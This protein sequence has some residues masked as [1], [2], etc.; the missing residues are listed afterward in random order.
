MKNRRARE[1]QSA[2]VAAE[3][4]ETRSQT[5]GGLSSKSA[6]PDEIR[7]RYRSKISSLRVLSCQNRTHQT[8]PA[9]HESVSEMRG[10]EES[11]GERGAP[12]N[13]T[14]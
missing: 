14:G 3:E 10:V 2:L 8:H 6:R 4:A 11:E 12:R 5:A 1:V 7:M 13:Q 9:I